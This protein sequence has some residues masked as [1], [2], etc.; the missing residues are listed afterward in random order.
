[1]YDPLIDDLKV[2]LLKNIIN[3]QFGKKYLKIVYFLKA[4]ELSSSFLFAVGS[5]LFAILKHTL[6]EL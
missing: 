6:S 1:M 4:N 2:R 5:D 3:N